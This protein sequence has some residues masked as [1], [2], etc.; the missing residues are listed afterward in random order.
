MEIQFEG[1]SLV[2]S[3]RDRDHQQRVL[4]KKVMRE[5]TRKVPPKR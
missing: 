4:M 2:Q 3:G 5:E 1:E